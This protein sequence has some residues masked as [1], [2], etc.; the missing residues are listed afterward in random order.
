MTQILSKSAGNCKMQIDGKKSA[1]NS[2]YPF[3]KKF[4]KLQNANWH[5]NKKSEGNFDYPFVKK[6]REIA[7]WQIN[8]RQKKVREIHITQIIA[9]FR[10]FK[11]KNL[12]FWDLNF[13]CQNNNY[14]IRIF[15]AKFVG[16]F[17]YIFLCFKKI[18]NLLW[19]KGTFCGISFTSCNHYW[20]RSE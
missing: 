19:L 1:G 8:I 18:G 16:F 7:N 3:G 2:N 15:G 17:F 20:V 9:D 11:R 4:G 5:I 12:L 6:I 13:S 10:I 14:A